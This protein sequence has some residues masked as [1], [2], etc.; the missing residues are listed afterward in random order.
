MS[1][2]MFKLVTKLKIDLIPNAVD[3]YILEIAV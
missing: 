3:S 1:L 2:N